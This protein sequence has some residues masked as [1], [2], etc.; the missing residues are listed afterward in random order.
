MDISTSFHYL[1]LSTITASTIRFTIET[2]DAKAGKKYRQ[3]FT[4]NMTVRGEPEV[5]D[6]SSKDIEFTCVTFEPDFPRFKMQG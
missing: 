3:T 4:D 6:L 2:A 1:T 5:S